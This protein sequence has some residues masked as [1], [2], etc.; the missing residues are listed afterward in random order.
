[1][2]PKLNDE[3]IR[4]RDQFIKEIRIEVRK[5]VFDAVDEKIMEIAD[6]IGPDFKAE[7]Q[8]VYRTYK[9]LDMIAEYIR[10]SNHLN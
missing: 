2:R 10:R 6:A 4:Y 9:K 1:M 8:D 3:E 7:I 5:E